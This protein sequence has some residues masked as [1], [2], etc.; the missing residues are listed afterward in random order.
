MNINFV[1]RSDISVSNKNSSKYEPL[2]DNVQKLKPGGKAL[3]VKYDNEAELNSMRNAVYA[4]NRE[5]NEDVKSSKHPDKNMV[6]FY[7]EK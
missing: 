6:F 7:K 5:Q 3:Q 4:Y 1:S 2:L